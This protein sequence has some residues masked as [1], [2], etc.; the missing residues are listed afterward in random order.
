MKVKLSILVSVLLCSVTATGQEQAQGLS[1]GLF[2]KKWLIGGSFQSNWTKI[3]G[4]DLPETY[5]G[6]PSV[7]G[8]IQG[9]YFFQERL[10]VGVG[11]GYQ[12]KG[13]G[14]K[15]PD[16]VKDLGDADSTNRERLRF[17]GLDLP[18]YLCYR[19]PALGQT[20]MRL[21]GR[22]G[23]ALSYNTQSTRIWHSVEDG[24]H[25]IQKQPDLY[26]RFGAYLVSSFGVDVNAGNTTLFQ[27]QFF[28]HQGLNNVYRDAATFGSAIGRNRG[29]GFQVGFFY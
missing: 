4:K 13:A 20:G 10:G 5:F 8:L 21:S 18:V 1:A 27:F 16:Y 26:D 23:P 12:Q 2:Q 7:S 14:I 22:L 29:Y 25:D 3:S 15:N 11:F 6:K 24:F 28:F 17:H 9:E 19:G